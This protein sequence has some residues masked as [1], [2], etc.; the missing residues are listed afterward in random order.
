MIQAIEGNGGVV[1]AF[2]SCSGAKSMDRLIDE[3]DPDPYEAIARRYLNIG[4]AIMTPN[5]CR[6][7]LIDRLVEEFHVQG[8]VEMVLSGCHSAGIESFSMKRFVN[9]EKHIPYL[10]IDTAYSAADYGQLN[11]RIGAFIEMIFDTDG[12]LGKRL[13]MLSACVS[14]GYEAKKYRVCDGR[15]VSVYKDSYVLGRPGQPPDFW[16][17]TGA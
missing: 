3:D 9:E 5:D 14:G 12:S 10:M 7:E 4:C 8:I 15:I 6:I 1:V 11:T 17:D 13:D 2:E 16:P